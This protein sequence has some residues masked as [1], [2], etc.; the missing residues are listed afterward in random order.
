MGPSEFGIASTSSLEL[1]Q[2]PEPL[3]PRLSRRLR[4]ISS[5]WESPALP[6]SLVPGSHTQAGGAKPITGALFGDSRCRQA[7]GTCLGLDPSVVYLKQLFSLSQAEDVGK[8]FVCGV[9]GSVLRH[10]PLEGT[11][12]TCCSSTAL[13]AG[14]EVPNQV[15]LAASS[16]EKRVLG[17]SWSKREPLK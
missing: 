11:F 4:C 8:C 14:V 7:P 3:L 12:D 6:V 9:G 10:H 15:S 13:T 1:T 2:H 17:W 16:A 5:R